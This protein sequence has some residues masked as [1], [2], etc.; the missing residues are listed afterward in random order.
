MGG[1]LTITRAAGATSLDLTTVHNN[2]SIFTAQQIME[3]LFTVSDDGK[4]AKPWLAKGY[5]VSEDQLT[6]TIELRDDVL[7]SN[8]DPLTA[9]DVKFSID[10]DTKTAESG[11]WGYIN[12]AIKDVAVVDDHTIT[13][14]ANYP[15]TPLIA[16]LAMFSN[17]IV[18][19]DYAGQTAEEFYE[20]PIGTGPFVF[21]DWKKGEYLTFVKNENYWQE[22]KPYLD[23][24]TWSVVPDV[25][26]RKLQLEGGQV[27]I[28]ESPDWSSFDSLGTT[29]GI[30]TEEFESTLIDHV[31]FNQQR[32]PFAD[33][34]VRR[35]IA[36]AIDRQALVDAVLFG[37]GTPA[38]SL[39]TPGT[40]YYDEDVKG[41]SLDLDKAKEEMAK[42]SVPD[43]FSTTLLISS[44][45]TEKA[46][47][48]QI[49]QA[50]LKEIGIDVTISPLDPTAGRAAINAGD[51]DMTLTGWTMDIPDPDQW[52]TFVVDPA[53]GANSDFTWYENPD[54]IKLNRDAQQE[55]DPEVRAALYT[56]LQEK[57]GEDAF[58]AYLYY[59][60][61]GYAMRDNV[62]DFF[63]TPLGNY[64][65]EDVYKTK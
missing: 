24:V 34:H 44:G 53:G 63:V 6:Y 12:A 55:A 50:E 20:A 19:N 21:S 16:D 62:K 57:T 60:P 13:I 45:N 11:G 9:A 18:P 37:H 15:W 65:L 58:L 3:P 17:T 8:G 42:S 39:L 43:G 26:T 61:Y 46:S 23:S 2:P 28:V 22:G 64:H 1:D 30:V 56:E 31:A 35:A 41:P 49:I 27:D 32:E 14:T 10:Q 52:T 33:V 4:D 7:F 47:N 36:Y 40:P 29:P 38:N 48:A 51:Y 59:S 25:N 54:V 5:E